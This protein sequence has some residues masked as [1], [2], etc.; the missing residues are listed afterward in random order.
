MA[1]AMSI[2]SSPPGVGYWATLVRLS[3]SFAIFFIALLGFGRVPL[4]CGVV[5]AV[6]AFFAKDPPLGEVGVAVA[7]F[8]PGETPRLFELGVDGGGEGVFDV[9]STTGCGCG[10]IWPL[11]EE[12]CVAVDILDSDDLRS[13]EIVG[14]RL[15]E[16]SCRDLDL[17]VGVVLIVGVGV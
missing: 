2:K 3:S 14:I 8:G 6:R 9:T 4:F 5:G 10:G 1:S 11:G 15:D 12:C 13:E 7:I 17:G 16:L